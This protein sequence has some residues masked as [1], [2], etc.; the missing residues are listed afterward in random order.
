[1]SIFMKDHGPGIVDRHIHRC[2]GHQRSKHGTHL[3]EM[4]CHIPSALV[5]G[6]GDYGEVRRTYFHP[7]R[8]AGKAPARTTNQASQ[9]KA[10][11]EESHDRSRVTARVTEM[12]PHNAA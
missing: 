6:V 3:L 11:F 5:A 1:M 8:F 2:L 10:D 12:V 9:R 7:L 4:E